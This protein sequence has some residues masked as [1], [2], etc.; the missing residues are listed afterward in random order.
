MNAHSGGQF[1]VA[2]LQF[3]NLPGGYP[4]S[5]GAQERFDSK[6]RPAFSIGANRWETHPRSTSRVG[7]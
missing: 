4:W 3:L 5:T 1:L 6:L 2:I 7:H